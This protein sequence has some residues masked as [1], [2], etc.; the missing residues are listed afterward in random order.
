MTFIIIA[1]DAETLLNYLAML[2]RINCWIT[3][4][5]KRKSFVTAGKTWPA[6]ALIINE[7]ERVVINEV[8]KEYEKKIINL[9]FNYYVL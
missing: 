5:W 2:S 4:I 3:R 1:G 8:P 6:T 7:L 9:L